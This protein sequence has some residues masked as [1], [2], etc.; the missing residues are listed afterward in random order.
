MNEISSEVR[1]RVV[2]YTRVSTDEQRDHGF[3]LASQLEMLRKHASQNNYEIA[4]E[5]VDGG[6]S[7]TTSDRPEFQRMLHDA[8]ERKFTLIL[9]YRVDRLFRNTKALLALTDDLEK[10]GIS[11]RSI[12]EPFDTS[13]YLGKFTLSLF[14]SIAQL[15]RDTMLDRSKQGRLRRAREGYYSGTQPAK[16]GYNYS[17]VTRKLEINEK[18]ADIVR[19]IFRLYCQPDASLVKVARTLRKLGSKTKEGKEF[20]SSVLHEILKDETYTGK[21]YANRYSKGGKLKPREQ[22]IVVKVPQIIPLEIFEEAGELLK[23]RRNHSTR[24]AKHKYL[25]QGMVKCG[26]CGNTVAGTADKQY[27]VK[28]GKSY[29]PYLKLYYRCTHFVKNRFEKVLRCRLRYVQ[30]EVLETSVWNKIEKLLENPALIETA[31]QSKEAL[32]AQ[33][34]KEIEQRIVYVSSRQQGLIGEE[35]RVLEAYRQNVISIEQLKE[36]V[37]EIRK[38]K[39]R[40]ERARQELTLSLNSSNGREE[41]NHAIDYLKKLREGFKK[42]TIESRKRLLHL[43]NAAVTVNVN[44]VADILC[45]L[46]RIPPV[47]PALQSA[48]SHFS[49]AEK[50]DFLSHFESP[51]YTCS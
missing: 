18:E 16:F 42:R 43:L 40:L 51:S 48:F 26:D 37:E 10:L 34:R 28:N 39:E 4:G 29:G 13:N 5:Y 50:P 15:E 19:F 3:S 11:L 20:E 25:L 27:Q 22:W 33:G 2:L 8:S 1:T 45:L 24:N 7:G 47:N 36:Q 23:T 6:H 21:W 14:G 41:V 9:V 32:S 35:K 44:G 30:A 17:K 38:E 31:V 46:P 12:T 49:D